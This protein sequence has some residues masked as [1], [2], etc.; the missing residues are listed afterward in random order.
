[1]AKGAYIRCR[2]S[3]ELKDRFTKCIA[4][5]GLSETDWIMSRVIPYIEK[6]EAKKMTARE[7]LAF[8]GVEETEENLY[9]LTQYI[10]SEVDF[11]QFPDASVNGLGD[12]AEEPARFQEYLERHGALNEEE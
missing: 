3:Q 6:K 4:K 11:S 5:D 9:R 12:D 8:A 1:M 2:V 10:D 7:F